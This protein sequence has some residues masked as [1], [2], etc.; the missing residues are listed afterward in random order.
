MNGR[1]VGEKIF[2]AALAGGLAYYLDWRSLVATFIVLGQGHFLIAYLYQARAGKIGP[3][4][5]IRYLF[6]VAVILSIYRLHP[7]AA[8]LTTIAT[9]Y[10]A[11]HMAVDELY[12][13]RYPL[14][15]NQS[16]VHGARVLEMLPF[17]VVYAAAVSDAMLAHGAWLQF[18]ALAG[19]ALTV[20]K[21]AY[22]AY[23]LLLALTGYRPDRLSVYLLSVGACLSLSSQLGWLEQVPAPKLSGFIILFHY[24]NWYLHYFLSLT[25]PLKGTYLKQVVSLNLVVVA[26]YRLVGATGL[27]WILFQERNFYVWT[28]LHL[29]TSTRP[30]DLKA[31]LR[32]PQATSG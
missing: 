14:K 29:I 3:S 32:W 20:A 23:L 19:P 28:L 24:F 7:F 13:T 17:I 8:G 2:S 4:Y 16:P 27:G 22:L 6:W 10:F 31:M 11:L 21:V 1:V 15:L 18:P 30:A 26:L 12:L 5:A 9:I 25:A